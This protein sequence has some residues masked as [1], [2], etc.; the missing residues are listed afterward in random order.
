MLQKAVV[1]LSDNCMTR[2]DLLSSALYSSLVVRAS[3]AATPAASAKK[4]V[5]AGG[6]IAGMSCA[7][8]LN[9]LGHDVTVLEASDRV[10]GHVKTVRSG[11]PDGLY[12]D[13]GA[14]QF[15]RPGYD[16]YWSYVKEFELPHV[17]D[18]RR[19]HMLRLIDGRM[20]SEEDLRSRRVLAGFGL[21]QREIAFFE[22]HP[23]WDAQ[24]LY[25]DRYTA[26]FSDE[27]KP[28][29][30][31]LNELDTVTLNDV[32]KK[33]GASDAYIRYAGSSGSALQAIWHLAILRLRGVPAWP[34]QVFRLIG[35]NSLLPETFAKHLGNRVKLNSPVRSIRH[36]D[37]GV[38][39]E[40]GAANRPQKL[41]AD[42]LVCCMSAVMLRQIPVT[43]AFDE[44]KRWAIANVPYY[45]ATRPIF[46][47]RTKFWREQQTSINVEFGQSTLEHV[48]SMADDVQTSRG[49]ITGTSQPGITGE[50]AL[51]TFRTY[52]PSHHDTIEKAMVVDWSKD[53]WCLACETT[54]YKPG[55]LSRFW[56][57]LIEPYGCI[58]F[59]GAYCDNLNWGQEAATRSANRVARAIHAA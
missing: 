22:R 45:S 36:G 30:A 17:Q 6:G 46:L 40:F 12:V 24:S 16:L 29:S 43:P 9:R 13:A 21:N 55:Q 50:K 44:R 11:L 41:D 1:A 2:R 37:R 35:G 53:P 5:V 58:Y 25:L 51:E 23:W 15:T 52:Y 34:T 49:L 54:S 32:L 56:P 48:W 38:T 26:K 8:E 59:A 47:A 18:H 28:F 39:V 19:E 4:V 33:E 27:Y 10:G 57:T 14:E 20:Y 3:A 7:Y 42:Y 31:G